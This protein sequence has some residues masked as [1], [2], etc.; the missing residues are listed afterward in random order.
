[1][2]TTI[3]GTSG[4]TFPDATS[5]ASAESVITGGV[6]DYLGSTAPTGWVMLSGRTMGN[7]SS[8]GTERANLDT[9]ALFTLLW[10]S[11][12]DTEAAVSGGRGAN[13][14]ADFAANKTITLPDARGRGTV[15][16]DDMGGTAANRITSGG[17]GI[18][19][20]TL[21]A[22]GGTQTHT[23]AT[24][25]LAAHGHTASSNSTGAHSHTYPAGSPVGGS[26]NGLYVAQFSGTSPTSSDGSHSHTIT[27]DSTAAGSAHQNTQP[28]LILNKIVKL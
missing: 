10:N 12:A 23:L 5:Q 6:I 28:S 17:S 7:A 9:E 26:T 21:G 11:M 19:G 8:G 2:T 20:T 22:S 1:M 16:K 27:V 25:E 18:T 14:A 13:A 15:G 4:I 24:G 3:N